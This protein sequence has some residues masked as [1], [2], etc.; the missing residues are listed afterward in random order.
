MNEKESDQFEIEVFNSIHNLEMKLNDLQKMANSQ[1][2]DEDKQYLIIQNQNART[3]SNS[4]LMFIPETG[5]IRIETIRF[6][7]KEVQ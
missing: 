7:N 5:S 6:E 4:N 2:N 3:Y 1:F